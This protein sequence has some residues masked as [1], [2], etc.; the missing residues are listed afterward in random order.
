MHMADSKT[1][2]EGLQICTPFLD[3]NTPKKLLF[4][5]G[6]EATDHGPHKYW[7]VALPLKTLRERYTWVIRYICSR[8]IHGRI[9][10]PDQ[11]NGLGL[12]YQSS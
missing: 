6:M 9:Y 3:S 12:L 8:I 5:G 7:P 11:E 10:T 4:L 2:A 1:E